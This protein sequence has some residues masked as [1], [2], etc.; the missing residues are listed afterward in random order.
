[1]KELSLLLPASVLMLVFLRCVRGGSAQAAH[2][3][4]AHFFTWGSG[5]G[6]HQGFLLLFVQSL[7]ELNDTAMARLPVRNEDG[8]EIV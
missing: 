1:V 7:L 3:G 4:G 6:T 8:S 5:G 2:G